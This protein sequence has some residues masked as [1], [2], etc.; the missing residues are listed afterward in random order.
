[1]QLTQF[2]LS[3]ARIEIS[4]AKCV[5]L[6]GRKRERLAQIM[7]KTSTSFYIPLA[8][9]TSV[10]TTHEIVLTGAINDVAA[11]KAALEKLTETVTR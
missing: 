5:L 4:S 1:M 6:F 10:K 8:P 9:L 11:A 2:G 7:Q 3:V